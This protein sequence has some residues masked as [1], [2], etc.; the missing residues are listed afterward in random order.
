MQRPSS[1][2]KSLSVWLVCTIGLVAYWSLRGSSFDWLVLSNT[3]GLGIFAALV[4]IP[5]AMLQAIISSQ[6]TWPGRVT[7]L[8]T[9]SLALIPLVFQVGSWDAAFGKLGWLTATATGQNQPMISGWSA[10]VWIHAVALAPQLALVFLAGLLT[11]KKV[12][13]DQALIDSSSWQV[14][15]RITLPRMAP[16]VGL[17][18][19]WCV[20]SCSREIAV[21]DIYQVGT[22]AEQVYLG[23]SLGQFDSF[24][25]NWSSSELEQ[26]DSLSI[27]LQVTTIAWLMLTS[28]LLFS[29]FVHGERHSENQIIRF[30]DARSSLSAWLGA[31]VVVVVFVCVP[32]W[33]LIVRASFH[34]TREN[35]KP[36]PGYSAE[37]F[38]SALRRA[39]TEYLPQTY[40]SFLIAGGCT[41]A[42]MLVATLIAYGAKRVVQVRVLAVLLI[43][44]CCALPGP[45]IGSMLSQLFSASQWS[46]V[47]YLYNRTLFPPILATT[48]VCLPVA[49]LLCWLI[50][51]E[52]PHDADEQMQMEGAGFWTRFVRMSIGGQLPALFGVGTLCFVHAYGELSAS[53][54]V[55][56]PGVETVPR[57]TLGLMHSGVNEMT[58][59][60]T[61]VNIVTIIAIS[62]VG[63]WLIS[64]KWARR[65][66][67]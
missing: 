21:T 18:V 50:L 31:F 65:K 32:T 48:I 28:V 42:V 38:F 34:V 5:L 3:L 51:S 64:L 8:I 2:R 59:A 29:R 27:L 54:M 47:E 9:L 49:V 56:P 11:G 10:A 46:W 22:L 35:G 52:A 36:T 4:A 43:A 30:R 33:N 61:I 20:I 16:Y 37:Q 26:A 7:L 14:F 66:Q 17:A 19:F 6:A 60:L 40:W 53:Q 67:Q 13:E 25:G 55:L 45:T 15:W 63:W 58:A 57:L 23:F 12:Y 24:M 62:L 39:S 1:F 41:F 44:I